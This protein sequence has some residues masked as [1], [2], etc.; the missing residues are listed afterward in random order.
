MGVNCIRMRLIESS[1][2]GLSNCALTT[3]AVVVFLAVFNYL[4]ASLL[5]PKSF[6]LPLYAPTTSAILY[7]YIPLTKRGS[8]FIRLQFH[9]SVAHSW[10]V[11]M[12]P[13]SYSEQNQ[14]C[15][16]KISPGM[17][18]SLLSAFAIFNIDNRLN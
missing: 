5:G 16:L 9:K 6:Y 15:A 17:K 8:G 1:L 2:T 18:A 10:C 4:S 3:S 7:V 11:A 13:A 12:V 14:A